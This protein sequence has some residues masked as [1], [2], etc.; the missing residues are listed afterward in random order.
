MAKSNYMRAIFLCLHRPWTLSAAL[1]CSLVVAGFWGANIGAVYPLMEVLFSGRSVPQ[2]V[3]QDIAACEAQIEATSAKIEVLEQRQRRIPSDSQASNKD[4]ELAKLRKQ[5]ATDRQTLQQLEALHGWASWLPRRPFGTL[6]VLAGLLLA[7]TVI[8]NLFLMA[9]TILVERAVRLAMLGV[10]RSYFVNGLRLDA[11]SIAQIGTAELTS[12]FSY[13]TATLANALR[14][15]FGRATIE[16]LKMA[17]CLI[18]AGLVSWRLLLISLVLVP[19]VGLLMNTLTKAMKRANRRGMEEMSR[20]I[21]RLAESIDG[22]QVVKAYTMEAFERARFAE[23]AKSFYR[24]SMK[25]MFYNALTKPV[26]ELLGVGIVALALLAGGYLVL[27]GQ[28]HLGGIRILNGPLSPEAFITFF[29]LLAGAADPARKLSDI[30][31]LI[32]PGFP[33]ADRVFEVID[34]QSAITEATA[35][36]PITSSQP[37]VTFEEVSFRYGD[38]PDI[39]HDINLTIEPGESLAIVGP[40][41]CGKSTLLN[42]L[43]RFHDPAGG[44]VK[45]GGVELKDLKLKDLRRRIGFVSQR[46]VLFDDTVV[47]NIGYGSPEACDEDIRNAAKQAHAHDFITNELDNGYETVVGARG[48]RLSGGQRQRIALARAILRDPE[49][50]VLDEATSQVD[51]ESERLIHD[52]LRQFIRNRTT[53]MVTHRLSTL[54]LADRILVMEDGR[55][56]DLGTHAELIARC[57]LYQRLHTIELRQSA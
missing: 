22:V 57:P 19:V 20:L 42:L 4:A 46:V 35:T 51:I 33:A 2:A 13:D 39:L 24:R 9:N 27:S 36:K 45:L 31:A 23:G 52:A 28:T 38:G 7:G 10:Q 14:S 17:A 18:G 5:Q 37:A 6:V 3:E 41:G 26:S 55:V 11:Q 30:F 44:S 1:V 54:A 12:R 47:A 21:A 32:Q 43:G 15:T 40:N 50:L 48:N 49:I 29:A 56:Q 8:K 25:I 34:R 16:P 53:I